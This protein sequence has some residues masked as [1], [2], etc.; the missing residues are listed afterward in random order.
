MKGRCKT[1]TSENLC[2]HKGRNDQKVEETFPTTKD[3]KFPSN[4]VVDLQL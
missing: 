3:M 4:L 2:S 1:I